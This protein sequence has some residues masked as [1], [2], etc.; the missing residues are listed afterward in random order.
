MIEG[1]IKVVSREGEREGGTL[2]FQNQFTYF[3]FFYFWYGTQTKKYAALKWNNEDTGGMITLLSLIS[4]L[5]AVHKQQL[6]A[7]PGSA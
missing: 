3:I 2:W 5:K 1:E 6:V 7:H 4:S